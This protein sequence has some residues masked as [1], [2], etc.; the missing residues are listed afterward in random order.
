MHA[1]PMN[2]DAVRHHLVNYF[3]NDLLPHKKGE[4]K[5]PLSASFSLSVLSVTDNGSL[6]TYLAIID[7]DGG[8][9]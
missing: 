4:K 2:C 5:S 8:S 9:W 7:F 3:H 6:I 1:V